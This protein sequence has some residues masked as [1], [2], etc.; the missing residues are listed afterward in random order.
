[1]SASIFCFKCF[2]KSLKLLSLRR[3]HFFNHNTRDRIVSS[4]TFSETITF[5]LEYPEP[6]TYVTF[7]NLVTVAVNM[8]VTK[9]VTLVKGT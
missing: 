3:L 9:R 5:T 7:R 4:M 6:H 1:M 2:L 8:V